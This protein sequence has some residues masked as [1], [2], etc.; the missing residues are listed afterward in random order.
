MFELKEKELVTIKR[1]IREAIKP[2]AQ[3]NIEAQLHCIPADE[4]LVQ[5][6]RVKP[7]PIAFRLYHQAPDAV[8]EAVKKQYTF[9]VNKRNLLITVEGKEEEAEEISQQIDELA[10][11]Y[12]EQWEEVL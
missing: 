6:V 7:R 12:A 9:L 2:K 11:C 1:H 4:L 8:K 10:I 3:L 5:L